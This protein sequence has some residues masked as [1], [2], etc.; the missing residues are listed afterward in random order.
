MSKEKVIFFCTN[1]G[2]ESSKWLGKCPT[3]SSWNSFNEE[4]IK[5]NRYA[6][7]IILATKNEVRDLNEVITIDKK[8]L[9]TGIDEL[10]R[11]FGGGIVEG[12]LILFG[13]EPGVGKSTLILQIANNLGKYG[14]V[15]YIS[16]EESD[17]QVK[18]RADRIKAKSENIMFYGETNIIEIEER[19]QKINPKVCIIDSIQTMYDEDI[20]STSGSISQVR[21]VTARLLSIS[22]KLGIICIVI[23][24]VTKEGIVAGPKLLE[25]MVDVVMY[26]EGDKQDMYRIVRG[27]KNRFGSTNEIGIF[28]MKENRINSC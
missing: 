13:G 11:V 1:C 9:T 16:G 27:A 3:C 6:S 10:D 25:H 15:L 28:E 18:L 5:E 17:I 14:K 4:K 2:Y 22:K 8:R 26:I 7:K 24:H 23:G 20:S 12:S 19:I 21:E